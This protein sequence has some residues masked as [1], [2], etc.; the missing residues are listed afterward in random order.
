[1]GFGRAGFRSLALGGASDTWAYSVR[2]GVE[3]SNGG[4]PVKHSSRSL[5][6][7]D[8][9]GPRRWPRTVIGSLAAAAPALAADRLPDLGHGAPQW[10]EDRENSRRPP[11]APLHDTHR[12][13]RDWKLRA[14]RVARQYRHRRDDAGPA[15]LRRH[16]RWRQ[17]GGHPRDDVLR[18]RW[19]RPLAREKPRELGA[20]PP[21]QRR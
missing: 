21:R 4:E 15:D 19:T 5:A 20:D 1:M 13:R 11:P 7:G 14:A 17:R 9:R 8:P 10:P 6:R 16:D 12:Q 2:V 3:N 18:R